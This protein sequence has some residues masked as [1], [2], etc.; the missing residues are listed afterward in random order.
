MLVDVLAGPLSHDTDGPR[1]PGTSLEP[2]FAG[3]TNRQVVG[4]HS[5]EPGGETVERIA[6]GDSKDDLL[7][8]LSAEHAAIKERLRQLGRHLSLTSAEQVEYAQLRKM[9]L[10]TKDRIRELES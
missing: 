8:Q 10:H 4:P 5:H 7:D 6:M 2:G 1:F 3:M 9:K